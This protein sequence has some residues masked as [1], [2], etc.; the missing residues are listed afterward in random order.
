MK[1]EKMKKLLVVLLALVFVLSACSPGG[2]SG[3]G[4]KLKIG[5]VQFVEHPALDDAR[6]GFEEKLKELGIDA[7]IDYK[8]AQ[9]DIPTTKTIAEK[10][11][12]DKVDLIYAIATPSAQAAAAATSDIPVLFSAVTN[13]E[14][15]K[16]VQSNEKPGGNVTGTIDAADLNAQFELFKK[17]DSNIET[18]GMIYTADEDNSIV[19]VKQVQEIAPKLGLKTVAKTINQLSDLPQIAQSMM[20]EAD[21]FYILTDNKI[22]SSIAILSDILKENKKVSVGAEVSHIKGGMLASKSLSYKELGKQTAEMA[23]KILVDKVKPEDIPVESAKNIDFV[24]NPETLEALGL[25]KNLEV[26]KD[27]VEV[28]K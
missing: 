26:F 11:V 7:E 18:V 6:I 2:E 15:N 10:F 12:S 27:A 23:K 9:L 22:A 19:Q 25:D 5:I 24:I 13:A 28:E 1:G 4:K 16:L 14:E 3:D 21:A 17:I 8:N 20:S